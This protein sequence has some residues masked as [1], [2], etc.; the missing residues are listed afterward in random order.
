MIGCGVIVGGVIAG[1]CSWIVEVMDWVGIS[2]T[3]ASTGAGTET[4]G[5]VVAGVV[6]GVEICWTGA[7]V[8]TEETV[9]ASESESVSK[10]D[11]VTDLL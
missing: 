5:G 8:C 9:D 2:S 1:G 10:S 3:G 11:S 7:T 4:G 6:V